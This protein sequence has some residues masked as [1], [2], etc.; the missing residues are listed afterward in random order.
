V[1]QIKNTGVKNTTKG[2]QKSNQ[3]STGV[4]NG[5]GKEFYFELNF[6]KFKTAYKLRCLNA[7]CPLPGS[8]QNI[9]F[10]IQNN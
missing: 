5:Q 7:I 9:K 4:E 10:K 1:P 3:L 6:G 2:V 8:I